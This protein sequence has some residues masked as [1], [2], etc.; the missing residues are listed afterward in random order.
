VLGLTL[1]PFLRDR[2]VTDPRRGWSGGVGG[3]FLPP[4]VG[5]T[6]YIDI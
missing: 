6:L 2:R 3:D 5:L 4:M 1:N